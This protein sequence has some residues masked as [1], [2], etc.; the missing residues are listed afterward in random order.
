M[1]NET[2]LRTTVGKEKAKDA[3]EQADSLADKVVEQAVVG[4]VG[5]QRRDDRHDHLVVFACLRLR[6]GRE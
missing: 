4:V 2:G 1:S 6:P 3:I 5:R